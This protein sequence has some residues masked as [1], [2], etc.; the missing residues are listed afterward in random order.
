[1]SLTI[2]ENHLY[3]DFVD[4]VEKMR[5]FIDTEFTDFIDCTLISIGFST[6]SIVTSESSFYGELRPG[7]DFKISGEGGCSKFV[8]DVV[9]PL[10]GRQNSQ[11]DF[12]GLAFAV[13]NWL[14]QFQ[15]LDHV[16]LMF[17]SA[18]DIGLLQDLLNYKWPIWLKTFNCK[19]EINE[20][21]FYTFMRDLFDGNAHHALN[22][23]VCNRLSWTPTSLA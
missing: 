10:L 3:E 12:N 11:Y 8:K 20:A 16:V 15:D 5:I 17:D 13:T 19:N 6:D 22:D 23:A 7:L 1:M 18:Y 21:M 4:Q 9:L 14:N 2:N